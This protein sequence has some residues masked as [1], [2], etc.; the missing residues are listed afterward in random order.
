[1]DASELTVGTKVRLTDAGRQMLL[2]GGV[3]EAEI[4]DTYT[5]GKYQ[6]LFGWWIM[7]EKLDNP[8][9][10]SVILFPSEFEVI[11]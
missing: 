11:G 5:L 10:D 9:A 2:D 8:I 3:T 7:A 6:D 4:L 1:M